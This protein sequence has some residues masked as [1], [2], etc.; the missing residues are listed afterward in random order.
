VTIASRDNGQTGGELH[1]DG[2][3]VT[4]PVSAERS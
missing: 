2:F 4:Q 3:E 1:I